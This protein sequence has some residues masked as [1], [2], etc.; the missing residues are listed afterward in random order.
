MTY[1]THREFSVSFVIIANALAWKLGIIDINYYISLIVLILFGKQGALFP[2]VD[3]I[4][5]N[6]KEKTIL[7][8]VINTIIHL[9]GGVHRSWQTHSWD[10]WVI[11]FAS[12]LYLSFKFL[13]KLDRTVMILIIFG[14]WSGWFSHLFSDML[15]SDGVR[16]FC[17]SKKSKISLVPK[18][19]NLVKNI[20]ASLLIIGVGVLTFILRLHDVIS[21]SILILGVVYLG[22]SLYIKNMKFNTGGEWEGFVY[23]MIYVLNITFYIFAV[24]FPFIPEI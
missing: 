8:K 15:S 5:R 13:N 20:I 6:V 1:K 14:F 22:F 23:K 24:V 16:I 18:Q 2:D 3:H 12:S 9:T 10:I 21:I 7:N 11:S 19:A 4:W 17:W